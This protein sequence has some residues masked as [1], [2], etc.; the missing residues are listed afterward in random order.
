VGIPATTGTVMLATLP[1]ILG[2]QLVLQALVLDINNI[3]TEPL[4]HS[5]IN[6]S[7]SR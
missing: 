7:G 6:R 4:H 1:F 3:P 2:F 5:H